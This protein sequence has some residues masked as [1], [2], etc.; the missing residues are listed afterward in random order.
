M[1]AY[2]TGTSTTYGTTTNYVPITVHRSD[3]GAVYFIKQKFTLGASFRDLSDSERQELQTNRGAVIRLV[4]DDTPAFNADLLVGD[5]VTEID[6][7]AVSSWQTLVELIRERTGKTV[8]LSLLRRGQKI[9]KTL[10]LNPR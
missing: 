10:Q 2:G 1:T 7:V 3:Y 9:R 8:I 4:V 5:V 6:G